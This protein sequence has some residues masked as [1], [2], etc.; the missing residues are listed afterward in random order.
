MSRRFSHSGG[1]VS[2]TL[3]NGWRAATTINTYDTFGQGAA[4]NVG[5]FGFAGAPFLAPAD[6]LH[7]RARAYQPGLG[8]FLQADPILHAGGMNLYAYVANDPVNA[9]DPWGLE[10]I[11]VWGIPRGNNADRT[12][13]AGDLRDLQRRNDLGGDRGGTGE[14]G[15]GD[16]VDPIEGDDEIV[17]PGICDELCQ[18]RR[19][20]EAFRH[21]TNSIAI[22]LFFQGAS[23]VGREVAIELATGGL[24]TLRY[25]RYA[26]GCFVEGTEVMTPDGLRAIED[27]AVGD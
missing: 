3:P 25:L 9:T 11:T 8:R 14:G 6:V 18:L 27:I 5:L 17:V 7:L 24:G 19:E 23:W 21:R 16:G 26:C 1:Q 2:Q 20:Q 15:G 12:W 4:S 10:T 22:D 13:S